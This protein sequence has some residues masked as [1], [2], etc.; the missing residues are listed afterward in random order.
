MSH[1]SSPRD[2]FARHRA[3]L[4][5][6]AGL[7]VLL[8][9]LAALLVWPM[10]M[11]VVGALRTA[12]PMEDGGRWSA[13]AVV[14]LFSSP[15]VPDALRGSLVMAAATTVFGVLLGATF[16]F[17]SERT[18]VPFR[19]LITP[20]M[21]MAAAIPPLFNTIGFAL[22]TNAS[23]G[24]IDTGLRGVL[25][26]DPHL[27]SID[28]WAGL[29]AINSMHSAGFVFLF[30]RGPVRALSRSPVEASLVSGASRLGTWLR[31]E[32]PLLFPALSGVVIIGFV[33]G[34]GIFDSVLL[35]GGREDITTISIRIYRLVNDSVPPDYATACVL[36]LLLLAVVGLLILLQWW[37]ARRRSYVSIS[38]KAYQTARADLG[39]WRPLA[40]VWV[41]VYGAASTVLPMAA[42][43][44]TSLQSYP[45]VYKSMSLA[46]YTSLLDPVVSGAIKNTIVLGLLG[47]AAAMLLAIVVAY[48]SQRAPRAVVPVLRIAT[49][50]PLG[51][52]GIV[53]ALAVIWAFVTL[54]GVR[55][56]YGTIWLLFVALV[57]VALPA[58]SQASNAAMSQMSPELEEASRVSGASAAR[59]VRDVTGRLL[60]PSFLSGWYIAALVVVGNLQVP[61]LLSSPDTMT[62]PSLSYA[63]YNGNKLG[64]AAALLSLELA[65]I[66]AVGVVGSAIAVVLGRLAR[67]RV[68]IEIERFARTPA[69][70]RIA[71][72]AP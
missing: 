33:V 68:P 42:L 64:E 28:T 43:V 30:M 66:A 67:R 56:L 6:R 34:L 72:E 8:A 15:G 17:L 20:L 63:L 58:A 14:H 23:T 53:A 5:R 52:P 32:L 38:G 45:G 24:L 71:E 49:F 60:L 3:F 48:A 31:I 7:I 35:L 70:G 11:L 9:V 10:L 50:I 2:R 22:A 62:I 39:R 21:V 16:A 61:L 36:A 12:P 41:L 59:T 25:G 4:R 47:G 19:R 54:P 26:G 40:G 69:R 51:M 55:S 65:G 27:L 37:Y 57:V 13:E 44:V 46:T 18:N 29:I 1:G